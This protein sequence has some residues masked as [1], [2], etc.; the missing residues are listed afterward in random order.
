MAAN[1]MIKGGMAVQQAN[2]VP[3]Q[4]LNRFTLE[5][6]PSKHLH[7]DEIEALPRPISMGG[8]GNG[9]EGRHGFGRG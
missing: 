9:V 8:R 5:W 2:L 1:T 4:T 3:A 6:K 7:H